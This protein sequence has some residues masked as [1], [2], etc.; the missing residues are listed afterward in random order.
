ML[1]YCMQ[2]Y[3][4]PRMTARTPV[5]WI[6]AASA[7]HD[8]RLQLMNAHTY[9]HY[10][11]IQTTHTCLSLICST[12]VSCICSCVSATVGAIPGRELIRPPGNPGP[13]NPAKLPTVEVVVA[14]SALHLLRLGLVPSALAAVAAESADATDAVSAIAVAVVVSIVG[15]LPHL[16]FLAASPHLFL[17]FLVAVAAAAVLTGLP[18]SPSAAC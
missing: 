9:T 2:A 8:C 1:L 13:G 10:I 14:P 5:C 12:R 7:I 15:V 4:V 11:T 3:R 17:R 18:S 16:L 6:R